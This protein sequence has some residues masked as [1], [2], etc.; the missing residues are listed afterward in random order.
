VISADLIREARLR[1]DLSQAELA[2][3]LGRSQPQIARWESGAARTSLETVVE[4]VRACGLELTTRLHTYDDSRHILI[5][6]LLDLP[7]S[8]RLAR[9]VAAANG[10]RPLARS[11]AA[12]RAGV[13]FD[14]GIRFDPRPVLRGLGEAAVRFVLIGKLAGNLRGDPLV[15]GECE[16]AV[17]VD[18]SEANRGAVAS[19]LDRLS[20]TP[21]TDSD[22]HPL[23]VPLDLRGLQDATRSRVEA[24]GDVLA[25]IA[26]PRGTNGYRDLMRS[27]T[28]EGAAADLRV[29]VASLT[30]LMRIAD[31]SLDLGDS[32]QLPTLR[33]VRE[34]SLSQAEP[35]R[36]RRDGRGAIR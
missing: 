34:L 27:A 15:P 35:Q 24:H 20:A 28:E 16:V 5:R 3:R 2:R 11:A 19:A 29:M 8:R 32:H 26:N 9:Q 10:F 14:E 21:W 31:A 7:P 4:A 12:Q 36:V 30:D 23:D 18:A 6:E 22:E 17:C 1:A 33:Q 25:V 13:E